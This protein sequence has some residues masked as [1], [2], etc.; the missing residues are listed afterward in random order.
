MPEVLLLSG[1]RQANTTLEDLL[2]HHRE[3]TTAQF[4]FEARTPIQGGYPVALEP[5]EDAA[6]M[7]QESLRRLGSAFARPAPLTP[8]IIAAQNVLR[9]VTNAWEPQ[10]NTF[11]HGSRDDLNNFQS[12]LLTVCTEATSILKRVARLVMVTVR[13]PVFVFGDIHGNFRDLH[14]FLDKLIPFGDIR[15][16][17]ASLLFLGDYVDRGPH[18]LECI[19]YLLSLFVMAAPSATSEH[20]VIT[21]LRGNHESPEVN[22]DVSSYGESSFLAQCRSVFRIFGAADIGRVICERINGVFTYLPICA[23]IDDLIFASHGGI[24]RYRGGVDDR[25]ERLLNRR[26]P[27]FVQVQQ[28]LPDEPPD[29]RRYREMTND[30][31]WSDPAEDENDPQWPLDAYGF[32]PN[33]RGPGTVAFGRAA[34]DHFLDSTGYQF[35]FRAHQEK[36]DGLRLSKSARVLTVFSSSNYQDH[37]N[38]A[39]VI[40]FARH[41]IR[42]LVRTEDSYQTDY[43]AAGP[44]VQ[45]TLRAPRR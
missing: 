3:R 26:F 18:S 40:F 6:I 20:G 19:S 2:R 35:M 17:P 28:A 1:E 23:S 42:L 11:N 15:Y 25:I 44:D 45:L 7:R 16:S 14:Y 22:S 31:L 12:A 29:Q 9:H 43:A 38:G 4:Q 36:A 30:I 41:R 5:E 24:P 10:R 39:G 33:P 8:A 27:R 37:A 34:V 21:L 32:G 13:S